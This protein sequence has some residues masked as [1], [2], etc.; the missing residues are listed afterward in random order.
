MMNMKQIRTIILLLALVMLPLATMA[1]EGGKEEKLDIPEGLTVYRV[2]NLREAI[3]T[4][5]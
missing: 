1:N 4:A 3:E 5:L 2:R